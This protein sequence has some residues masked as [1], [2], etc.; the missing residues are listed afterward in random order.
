MHCTPSTTP[1]ANCSPSWELRN[2]ASGSQPPQPVFA[3]VL[4]KL[5]TIDVKALHPVQMG[6]AAA[7]GFPA[8]LAPGNVER[9]NYAMHR[10]TVL[11][12]ARHRSRRRDADPPDLRLLIQEPR[13]ATNGT[14]RRLGARYL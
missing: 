1:L 7:H 11:R 5:L 8:P 4:E 10:H 6:F 9:G 2:A 3:P 12:S 13:G 14:D